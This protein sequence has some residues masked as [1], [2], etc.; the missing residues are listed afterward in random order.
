MCP[1]LSAVPGEHLEANLA[2]GLM[3]VLNAKVNL[4][5]MTTTLIGRK[6]E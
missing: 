1:V 2:L 6:V 4:L 5:Q 3:S